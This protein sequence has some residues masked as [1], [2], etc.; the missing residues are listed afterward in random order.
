MK[1]SK[2]DRNSYK[3]AWAKNKMATD[4]QYRARVRAQGL[5]SH[6]RNKE[7]RLALSRA[8]KL[9]NLEKVKAYRKIYYEKNKLKER[10]QST[11]WEKRNPDNK[12]ASNKRYT[13]K[14]RDLIKSK[15]KSPEYKSRKNERARH[16]Y[17][18]DPNYRILKRIRA[19]FTQ[20]LRLYG[21][22][23]KVC[24]VTQLVGCTMFELRQYLESK[25][26]PGMTWDNIHIDHIRPCKFFNFSDP[27]QQKECFHYSNLQP[28]FA[29]DNIRKGCSL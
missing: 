2:E 27:V 24:S 28:L 9:K 4:P 19:S 18:S 10:A 1:Q 20:A 14:H 17:L 21:R 11:A 29:E 3:Y 5:A 25:F 13:T 26:E 15:R 7:K 12:K 6:Y 22:H 8:W 16:R 23:P